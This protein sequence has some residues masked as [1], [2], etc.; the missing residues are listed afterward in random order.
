MFKELILSRE[1]F[2]IDKLKPVFNICKIAGRTDGVVRSVEYRLKMSIAKRGKKHNPI[3]SIAK[4]IRQKCIKHNYN[5][6]HTEEA[7]NKISRSEIK[8]IIQYDLNGNYI[9]E[10]DSIKEASIALNICCVSISMCCLKKTKKA[11]NYKWNFKN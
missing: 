11:G 5:Y 3:H 9:K 4:S 2:F 7:K 6:K 1:Q 10:W 8:S